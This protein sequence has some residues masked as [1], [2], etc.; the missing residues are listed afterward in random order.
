MFLTFTIT[1]T[2]KLNTS[3]ITIKLSVHLYILDVLGY[4]YF[5]R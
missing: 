1:Q 4:L 3:N 5:T 2:F